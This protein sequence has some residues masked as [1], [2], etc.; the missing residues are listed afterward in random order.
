MRFIILSLLVSTLSNGVFAADSKRESVETL[1]ELTDADAMIDIMY[2]Q[3][4]QSF[5]AIAQGQNKTEAEQA[6]FEENMAAMVS[7]MRSELNWN[8]FKGPM[9]DIYLRNFSEEEIR[10]MVS[11]YE[12]DVGRSLTSKMPIVMAES[13]TMART[14]MLDFMPRLMAHLKM[15]NE[16]P[17]EETSAIEE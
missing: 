8:K 7:F 11:F 9:V 5:Q 3:I 13:A 14:L 2:A 12:S 6:M 17:Q 15:L 16:S 1:L 10:G 4:S